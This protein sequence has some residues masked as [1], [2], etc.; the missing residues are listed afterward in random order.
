MAARKRIHRRAVPSAW[1]QRGLW[2]R[3]FEQITAYGDAPDELSL[4]SASRS[5]PNGPE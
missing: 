5:S 2:Q 3:L 1:S 4:D